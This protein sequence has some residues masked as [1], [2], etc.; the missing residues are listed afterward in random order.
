MLVHGFYLYLSGFYLSVMRV[1]WEVATGQL[2]T[3]LA[4]GWSKLANRFNFYIVPTQN[5]LIFFYN[6]YLIVIKYIYI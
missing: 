4:A 5:L 1:Q 3:E 6:R 2:L